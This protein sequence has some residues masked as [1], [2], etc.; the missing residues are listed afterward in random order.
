LADAQQPAFS[1]IYLAEENGY[2]ADQNIE[3]NYLPF[4]SGRDAL[5]A[6]VDGKA[7]V[8]TVFKTPI[9]V[10]SLKGQQIKVITELHS[11]SQNIGIVARR[12]RDITTLNQLS[13]KKVAVTKSSGAEFVA[14]LLL[15]QSQIPIDGVNW[16]EA[17]PLEMV[18]L[19]VNGEVD[20]I[21]SWNP[22]LI[23]AVAELGEEN[24]VS[25]FTSQIKET[26]VLA[27]KEGFVRSNEDLF[28]KALKA[29]KQAE[30]FAV[31]NPEE[32]LVIVQ[33][34]L[35]DQSADVVQKIWEA[36]DFEIKLSSILLTGMTEEAVWFK[37][38]NP[39]LKNEIDFREV[40]FTDYLKMVSPQDVS[41]LDF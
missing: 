15:S 35:S 14:H 13:G 30:E 40:I 25:F 31:E 39:D 1:L 29:L 37:T 2:F 27:A 5:A 3:I 33:N 22:H 28:K 17:S 34:K 36:I 11:S 19:L 41:I 20:A 21:A 6:V 23:N 12:D 26:S 9:V 16:V 38:Q 18:P 32:A 8:A 4:N 10:N 24:T 7:D